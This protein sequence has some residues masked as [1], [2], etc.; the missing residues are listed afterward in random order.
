MNPVSY[1]HLDVYKRQAWKWGRLP[2]FF[3]E[4][5]SSDGREAWGTP[6]GACLLYTSGG[7]RGGEHGSPSPA[8]C[9][10]PSRTPWRD[11]MA[12]ST[13]ARLTRRPAIFATRS[14]LPRRTSSP[15]SLSD[16]R[17]AGQKWPFPETA[18]PDTVKR[19]RDRGERTTPDMGFPTLRPRRVAAPLASNAI[20]PVLSLIHI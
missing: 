15:F 19:P 18:G 7:R 8:I 10:N 16:P 11:L 2:S 20:P 5:R 14:D 9:A 1:T 13:S 17:S 4:L 6:S 3:L 12:A